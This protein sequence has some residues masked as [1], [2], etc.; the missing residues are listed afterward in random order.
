MHIIDYNAF[1]SIQD[2]G[3]DNEADD[4]SRFSIRKHPPGQKVTND[5]ELLIPISSIG[6][7]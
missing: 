5:Q 2:S 1:S 3:R 6:R 7:I 4:T